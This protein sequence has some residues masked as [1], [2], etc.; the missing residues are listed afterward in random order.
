MSLEI[1]FPDAKFAEPLAANLLRLVG[2][3]QATFLAWANGGQALPP[4]KEVF[5]ST[6]GRLAEEFPNFLLADV[7]SA[8]RFNADGEGIGETH[9]LI[10]ELALAKQGKP[11]RWKQLTADLRREC[12]RYARAVDMI[13]RSAEPA[14]LREGY[15]A[16]KVAFQTLEVA[17]HRRP[18]LRGGNGEFLIEQ[19]LEVTVE[20]FEG[21]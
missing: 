11:E 2:E 8:L 17:A 16:G 3:N 10:F 12:Y 14:D 21:L 9:T 7:E 13:F 4:F 20:M 1:R 19:Q 6:G 15:A 18:T 5:D